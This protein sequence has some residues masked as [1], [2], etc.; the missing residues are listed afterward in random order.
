MPGI[1]QQDIAYQPTAKGYS[2]STNPVKPSKPER[3]PKEKLNSFAL[4][5]FEI[6]GL[7]MVFVV[8]LLILNFF[9]IISLS[10]IYPR[11]LG[12][13]PHLNQTI[14]QNQPANTPPLSQPTIGTSA[15]LASILM[16]N[17]PLP[18]GCQNVA[19]ISSV[20]T[21][22]AQGNFVGLGFTLASSQSAILA[23]REG[24]IS[25]TN[26]TENNQNLTVVT[27]TD[28][29]N[30]QQ[31]VY[32]FNQTAYSPLINSGNV[33]EGQKI[34]DLKNASTITY[35]SKPYSFIL[36]MY[37]LISKQYLKL[38]P[39]TDGKNLENPNR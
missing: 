32:K 15:G 28:P 2:F 4:L 12:F 5:A 22:S 24:K 3:N 30:I 23:M 1:T 6:L 7:I 18:I 16:G 29:A 33:K 27:I 38:E 26:S 8:F 36:S 31:Y 11:E 34:G 9:N 20:S 19:Q 10:N 39:S 14:T 13:L 37:L 17:C 35:S 21:D 25:V